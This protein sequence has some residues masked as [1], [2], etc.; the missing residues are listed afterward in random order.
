MIA[1]ESV[2]FS[3]RQTRTRFPFRYGIASMTELPHL[4]VRVTLSVGG[5]GGEG[6]SSEGL[7]PKWFTKNPSTTF[8]EDLPE[9]VRV[10][11]SAADLALALP[12][13]PDVF[14]WWRALMEAQ[15]SW[16]AKEGIPPL[17]AQLGTSLLERAVLDA[18]CRISGLTLAEAFGRDALGFRV[19]ALHPGVS[20]AWQ[21]AFLGVRPD[22]ETI[23]RHTVGL[24]DPLTQA[25]VPPEERI[26][27]GLPYVLEDIIPRYGLTRFKIKLS[28]RFEDDVERLVILS[29][30]LPRLAP[31]YRTTLDANEQYTDFGSFREI[32]E[33][34]R[35]VPEL[36]DLLSPRRLMVVEQPLRRDQA[37]TDHAGEALIH[38]PERPPLIID[39]SDASTGSVARALELGYAGASHKN[40]KGVFKGMANA[41]LLS[42]RPGTIQ[43]GEDLVNIGPV[44]LLQDLAVMALLRVTDVERNGHHYMR[45][46]S[47]FPQ[48]LGEAVQEAHPDLYERLPDG[49]VALTLRRGCLQLGTVL[50]APF[51]QSIAPGRILDLAGATPGLPE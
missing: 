6:L 3:H 14:S 47:G 30:L 5:H 38:W 34:M 13:Q 25:G 17:L 10:I 42:T 45:G 18:F 7:A 41:L 4:F 43:T 33:R 48:E 27:D 32:W 44:A 39:E 51:G 19:G 21:R 26:D 24:G 46:L 49:T 35:E 23:A 2:S 36:A 37:L 22:P 8:A 31:T 12:P 20:D 1:V 29:E 40:C 28:G 50:R 9:M 15:T 11:Q 16:A